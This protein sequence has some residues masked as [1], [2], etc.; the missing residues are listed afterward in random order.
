[1][2]RFRR[3]ACAKFHR[4]QFRLGSAGVIE[5]YE[6]TIKK[7]EAED[8]VD[9]ALSQGDLLLAFDL[10]NSAL[11][12]G[13]ETPGIINKR[14]LALARM[15]EVRRALGEADRFGLGNRNDEDS[16]AMRARLL[17]DLALSEGGQTTLGMLRDARDAYRRAHLVDGGYYSAINAA[18]LSLLAGE[19]DEARG[20]AEMV[21]RDPR[22]SSPENYYAAASAVEALLLLERFEDA[23]FIL[24]RALAFPDADVSKRATTLRQ[25]LSLTRVLPNPAAVST[26]IERLRPPPVLFFAGHLFR[27]DLAVEAKQR[28]A[29]DAALDETQV[30]AGYGALAAGADILFAEALLDRG[31]QL[32]VVLP[33]AL[34]DFVKESVIPFGD[35]WIARFEKTL[36]GAESIAYASDAAFAGDSGQFGYGNE[37]AMGLACLRA[38][39]L[40]T[41]AVLMAVW[42]EKQ[43][44]R[45]GG[46]ATSVQGWRDLGRKVVIIDPGLIDRSGRSAAIKAASLDDISRERRAMIFTDY[47]GFSKLDEQMLP[48]FW[49][50]IMGRI[51]RIV[52][53]QAESILFRNTWGD[54]LYA[55]VSDP[56]AAAE[57]AMQLKDELG[58]FDPTSVGLPEGGGMRIALHYGPIYRA[59]DQ[60]TG[61]I[62]Y[63]GTEVTLTARVEPVTPVGQVYATQSYAALLAL[64]ADR[65]YLTSYVGTVR[66]AKAFGSVAMHKLERSTRQHN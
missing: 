57:I 33:F 28:A 37:F 51:G 17:K 35:P 6:M 53:A 27:A 40:C 20:L 65:R 10:A 13:I 7:R 24:D 9:A 21:L 23:S 8:L 31:I 25:I 61:G 4:V 30:I 62:G 45:A 55:V 47:A 54:A 22:V 66:L 5:S 41:D 12:S 46:T 43:A 49:T 63:F 2:F 11:G 39:H 58:A 32:N 44:G 42:D 26:M 50:E 1:M 34:E 59:T 64:T 56:I 14:I 38:N 36:A 18:T 48:I 60:I 16:V 3:S 52:N 19:D 15:G 29:I